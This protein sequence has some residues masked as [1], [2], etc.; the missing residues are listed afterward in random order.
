MAGAHQRGATNA[1][2]LLWVVGA[3]VGFAVIAGWAVQSNAG[4]I[5]DDLADRARSALSGAPG[6]GLQVEVD[7]RDVTVRGR[8]DSAVQRELVTGRLA[9]VRGARV[10]K[11]GLRVVPGLDHPATAPAAAAAPAAP[12]DAWSSGRGSELPAL[13]AS[14]GASAK[15]AA[16]AP[17]SAPK[18]SATRKASAATSE[19]TAAASKAAASPRAAVRR[20]DTIRFARGS[21]AL[22]ADAR[23]AVAAFARHASAGVVQVY[24]HADDAGSDWADHDLSLDRAAA[25]A[26][27]LRAAG[28]PASR[29][30][31]HGA[32]DGFPVASAGSAANRRVE[33]A[34]HEAVR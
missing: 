21:A 10:V 32:G 28:V 4:R 19:N 30:H 16:T 33:L 11:D 34:L 13:R 26:R 20:T 29:I 18:R 1:A 24:G 31:T 22:S 15:P 2:S 27:A 14:R 8:V 7:G 25:V 9:E 5:Q 23:A 3:L 17:A 12:G 6:V